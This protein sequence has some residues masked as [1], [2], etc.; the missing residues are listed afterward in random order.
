LVKTYYT[1][2]PQPTSLAEHTIT[3][4]ASGEAV[5]KPDVA[6]ISL[7]VVKE[8]DSVAAVTTESNTTMNTIIAGLKNNGV[9]EQDIKTTAYNLSPKY[10]YEKQ[11][12]DIAGY[13][14]NQTVEV[15]V[16]DFEKISTLV[17]QAT[18]AGANSVSS[19]V[20]T[21]D[22]A[23]ALKD[24]ARFNAFT[25]AQAKAESL[26]EAANVHLGEVVTFTENDTE[27]NYPPTP[28]YELQMAKDTAATAQP[29]FE[30]G[31]QDVTVNVSVTF[32]IQ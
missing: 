2:N 23:E 29:T 16:R 21:I 22:D 6:K 25:K 31:S 24:L 27:P 19:P 17:D 9:E 20:F 15:K 7:A 18:Q 1:I 11:P 14:L 10:N 12:Y 32:E 26:A 3:I 8:G 5:G 13:T 28:Y 4:A 30:G